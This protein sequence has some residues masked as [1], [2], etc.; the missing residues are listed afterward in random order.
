MGRDYTAVESNTALK[1]KRDALINEIAELKETIVFPST[2][3][4][5]R[6]EITRLN[7]ELEKV[8]EGIVEAIAQKIA[9]IEMATKESIS[10]LQDKVSVLK[11]E[12]F[13]L[14][15]NKQVLT[16]ALEEL[17]QIKSGLNEDIEKQE[18]KID[19]LIKTRNTLLQGIDEREEGLKIKEAELENA[20]SEF[21][22]LDATLTVTI[23]RQT[24]EDKRLK[25]KAEGIE[26]H[27][28]KLQRATEI[29]NTL[30]IEERKKIENEVIQQQEKSHILH[31]QLTEKAQE[32]SDRENG[33]VKRGAEIALKEKEIEQSF[34][35]L[36][37]NWQVYTTAE[38]KIKDREEMVE[39]RIAE[40]SAKRL[41]DG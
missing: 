27:N 31:N 19:Q 36:A 24:D 25:E 37:I 29:F 4:V 6:D 34:K 3:S 22:T 30:M 14:E 17:N 2:I 7:A 33:I 28:Q 40:D 38:R 20:H 26:F 10:F 12:V 32:L 9:T 18:I 8:R 15:E 39:R 23:Q 16:Y 35:D 5:M 1:A 41:I 21:D 13:S 11:V